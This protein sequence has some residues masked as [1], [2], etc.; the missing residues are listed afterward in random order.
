MPEIKLIGY[1]EKRFLLTHNLGS[2]SMFVPTRGR[3]CLWSDANERQ[4][5]K[6]ARILKPRAHHCVPLY[7]SS[8]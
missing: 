3:C 8:V 5:E 6:S 4:V 7:F 2:P 1:E